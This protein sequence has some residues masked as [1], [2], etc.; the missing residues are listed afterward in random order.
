MYVDCYEKGKRINGISAES[1]G[2]DEPA[3][4]RGRSPA[5]EAAEAPAVN[6]YDPVALRELRP[7]LDPAQPLLEVIHAENSRKEPT[8]SDD[9][10]IKRL[11]RKY[12]KR[13]AALTFSRAGSEGDEAYACASPLTP[14]RK[15]IKRI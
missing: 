11:E 8:Q 13:R 10:V 14:L 6:E 9:R 4:A 12:G 3:G 1:D 5:S 7:N 15:Q 2:D